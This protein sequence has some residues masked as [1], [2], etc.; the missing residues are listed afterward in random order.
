MGFAGPLAAP[1]FFLNNLNPVEACF[2]LGPRRGEPAFS[3]SLGI[4]LPPCSFGMG[5]FFRDLG[6]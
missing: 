4:V 6:S 2:V 5:F 1:P 3:Q